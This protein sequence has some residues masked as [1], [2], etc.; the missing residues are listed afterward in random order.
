MAFWA[1]LRRGTSRSLWVVPSGGVTEMVVR[2]E[3]AEEVEAVAEN[4]LADLAGCG[5]VL[6]GG[7]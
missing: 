3:G 6:N 5:G 7:E 1:E 4:D 2:G